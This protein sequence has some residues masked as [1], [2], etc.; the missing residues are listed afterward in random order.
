VASIVGGLG[1]PISMLFLLLVGQN[2]EVMGDRV[3][4]RVSRSVG[5]AT[6]LLVSGV[7]LYFLWQQFFS[8]M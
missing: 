6:M 2:Q 1:T 8:Q 4:G 5:W 7:S 3:I